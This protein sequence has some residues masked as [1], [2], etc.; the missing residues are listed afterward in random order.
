MRTDLLDL[1]PEAIREER[2]Q[3]ERVTASQLIA[4]NARGS[5]ILEDPVMREFLADLVLATGYLGGWR[6]RVDDFNQGVIFAGHMLIER[7]GADNKAKFIRILAD[8][9]ARRVAVSVK[10]KKRGKNGK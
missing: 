1:E 10:Q 9:A 6:G 5:K 2:E 4:I 7:L 8:A 3:R